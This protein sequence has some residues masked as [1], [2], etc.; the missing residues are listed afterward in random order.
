ML[1]EAVDR[2]LYGTVY[3]LLLRPRHNLEHPVDVP[4]GE[5]DLGLLLHKGVDILL[6]V[7]G[8]HLRGQK[9]SKYVLPRRL[10]KVLAEPV[11]GDRGPLNRDLQA[12]LPTKE[13]IKD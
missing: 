13:P 4:L 8:G 7:A 3:P 1:G 2:L 12:K 9:L 10:L 11:T 6:Q 5:R